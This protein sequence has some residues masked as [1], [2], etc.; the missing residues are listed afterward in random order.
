MPHCF[1]GETADN[2]WRQAAGVLLGRPAGKLQDS[3]SGKTRELL[4]VSF[5]IRNPRERW[6]LSRQPGINPAFA[7]AEVVWILGGRN[8]SEFINYW[9]PELQKFAG[10]DA[11]YHGAYGYRLRKQFGLDQI[12]RAYSA[13][14]RN[15]ESRQIVLQIWD[16]R[17]D[18][19]REDGSPVSEDIP[20]NVCSLLKVRDGHLEWTQIM[21]SNDLLLGTPHNFVQF[22]VLQEIIAGWLRLGLGEYT[23][24]SDSL[25]VYEDKAAKYSIACAAPTATNGDS[26][27][28]PKTESDVVLR[29]LATIAE[30]LMSPQLTKTA[31]NNLCASDEMPAGYRNLV[32][33]MAADAARR[34][35]WYPEMD[36][37]AS[38]CM[39]FALRAA[40][41]QW[42]RRHNI[43]ER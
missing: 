32:L 36:R 33:T 4:H 22:T 30:A 42:K 10:K 27:L 41:D 31:F 13:L 38:R 25:H 17:S 24:F 9:N 43:H 1:V 21:R 20:C 5:H 3:R 2:V 34:R 19:P 40:W 29:R 12:E 26:L 39:N 7:V 8:D 15:P 37:A 23:H 35:E 11:L 16:S 14:K 6:V 28:L 18:L